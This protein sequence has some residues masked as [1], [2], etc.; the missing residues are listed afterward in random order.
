S[1]SDIMRDNSLVN[2]SGL[3]GHCMGVDLNIEH[4]IGELKELLEAKGMESTWD[5]LGNISA[6]VH[7]IKKL[8]RQVSLTM[9]SSYQSKTHTTPNTDHLV[10]LVANDIQDKKL[11]AYNPNR[12]NSSKVVAVVDGMAVGEQKLKSSTISTFNRKVKAMVT[13]H[14]YVETEQDQGEEDTLPPIAITIHIQ[15]DDDALGTRPDDD[16]VA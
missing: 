15:D 3:E 16:T 2:V 8:K 7:L 5:R 1:Y 12:R 13:G 6:S 4:L 11:D 10:W 9:S 14:K